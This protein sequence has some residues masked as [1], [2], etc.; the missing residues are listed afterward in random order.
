MGPR[1]TAPEYVRTGQRNKERSKPSPFERYC[2]GCRTIVSQ[3]DRIGP[4]CEFRIA[5]A[6]DRGRPKRRLVAAAS[7]IPFGIHKFYLGDRQSG[8]R[9]LA[10]CWTLVP[11]VVGVYDG[12]RYL[13][14]SDETFQIEYA[15]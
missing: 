10:F 9:Y 12:L 8:V 2:P 7:A 5:E 1:A 4:E 6:A 14:A 13:Q 11:F 3:T 15:P